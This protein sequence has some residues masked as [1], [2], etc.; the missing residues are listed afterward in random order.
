MSEKSVCGWHGIQCELVDSSDWFDTAAL[1]GM[2]QL[3]NAEGI[4]EAKTAKI[5]HK[6][7]TLIEP[8]ME[9]VRLELSNNN[10]QG[11]VPPEL[12]YVS[13][14]MELNLS[15]NKLSGKL[16]QDD[17]LGHFRR[18]T[19][20]HLEHNR[21]TGSIPLALGKNLILKHLRLDHNSLKG[22]IPD[23]MVRNLRNLQH[24]SLAHNRLLTGRIPTDIAGLRKIQVL[25][26]NDNQLT[27]PLPSGLSQLTTL[28][29]FC[30]FLF[31]GVGRIG[32][33]GRMT[34]N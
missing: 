16:P 23:E 21:L 6:K 15:H 17:S 13:Q 8:V 28:R 1:Q 3:E 5:L 4:N 11:T 2:V 14:L 32:F 12:Q 22:S 20:L 30:C 9:V 18:L 27:G 34:F 31:V 7:D 26:W 24:W 29:K 33:N 10:L 19:A 25:E